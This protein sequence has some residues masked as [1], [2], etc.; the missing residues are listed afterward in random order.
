MRYA[1]LSDIH[2]NLHAL[3]AV[4]TAL[5]SRGVESY[6]CA[7]DI[8]GYG[9]FPNECV[10]LVAGLG[11]QCVAG[12]HDLI[13]AGALSEARSGTLARQT[14]AWT[15]DVMT[16]QTRCYLAGLPRT[17]TFG[18]LLVAHGSP[19]DPEEYVRT[20]ERARELMN[21]VADPRVHALV[22]GH[23]HHQWAV[24]AR[25]GQLLHRHPGSVSLRPE[26]RYVLNPGSVGQ[27]RDGDTLARFLVLD[28]TAWTAEFCTVQ[29]DAIASAGALRRAGLP[30]RSLHAGDRSLREI[31]LGARRRV[32]GWRGRVP[33]LSGRHS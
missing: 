25:D 17:R 29:Y 23:T 5:E 9:P 28:T 33:P 15:R 20:P 27:S 32:S 16:A 8:V 3:R 18:G 11:A 13:A 24:S 31:A 22:L 26:G 30:V 12:N 6:V 19:H 10:E 7:G 1:V 21:E 14:L 4:L 2:A